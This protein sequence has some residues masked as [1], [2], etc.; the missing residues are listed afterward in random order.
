MG[1]DGADNTRLFRS[2]LILSFV[3][4]YCMWGMYLFYSCP[5]FLM[6]M[7]RKERGRAGKG[8]SADISWQR[9]FSSRSGIHLLFLRGRILGLRGCPSD[10]YRY[11]IGIVMEGREYFEGFV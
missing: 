6:Q 1:L 7:E 4:C 2:T 5:S 11:L 3:S 10:L 8:I 9:S